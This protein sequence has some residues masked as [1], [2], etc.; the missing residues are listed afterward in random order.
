MMIV[1]ARP[2]K[3]SFL[4]HLG[5]LQDRSPKAAVN[6]SQAIMKQI[7]KLEQN[8]HMGRPGRWEDTRELVITKYPYIVAYR[9]KV[10]IIEI[11]YIHHSRQDWPSTE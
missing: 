4:D 5:F 10:D 7:K 6:V 1:W 3:N 2:A 8:P 9:L 11:L